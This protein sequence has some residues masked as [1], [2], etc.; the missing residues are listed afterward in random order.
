M[1]LLTTIDFPILFVTIHIFGL[2]GD[3]LLRIG[4]LVS[5]VSYK[6]LSSMTFDV[7]S[8]FTSTYRGLTPF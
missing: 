3:K 6:C 2:V 7:V 4:R 8:H 5:I 1:L